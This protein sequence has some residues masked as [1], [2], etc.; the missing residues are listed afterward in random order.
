[1]NVSYVYSNTIIYLTLRL[2]CIETSNTALEVL[3]KVAP[4]KLETILSVTPATVKKN[5]SPF[6]IMSEWNT[7]AGPIDGVRG[8]I[9]TGGRGLGGINYLQ[10][11]PPRLICHTR[12]YNQQV[13]FDLNASFVKQPYLHAPNNTLLVNDT[14]YIIHAWNSSYSTL[15][16]P[17]RSHFHTEVEKDSQVVGNHTRNILNRARYTMNTCLYRNFSVLISSK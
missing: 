2:K 6:S 4:V 14:V 10:Q 11:S 1:M 9:H 7:I 17:H 15:N 12:Q 16:V 5:V 13:T 3:W 8:S